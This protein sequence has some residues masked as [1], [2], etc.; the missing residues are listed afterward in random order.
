MIS[1][2]ELKKRICTVQSTQ[3]ITKVMSL[4]SAS[5]IKRLKYVLDNTACYKQIMSD[6]LYITAMNSSEKYDANTD[7]SVVIPNEAFYIAINT[8]LD[9]QYK[10]RHHNVKL[11]HATLARSPYP[12]KARQLII[13]LTSDKGL[14]GS[15]NSSIIRNMLNIARDYSGTTDF[16]CVGKKSYEALSKMHQYKNHIVKKYVTLHYKYLQSKI[17]MHKLTTSI[18]ELIAE[19]AYTSVKV[20]YTQFVT[21]LKQDV[22]VKQ[23]LPLIVQDDSGARNYH[24]YAFDDK[25]YNSLVSLLPYYIHSIVHN[26]V[27]H[28]FLSEAVKRM[29]TMDNATSNSQEMLNKY[30]L[31]YNRMRQTKVTMELIEVI[32]GMQG[33]SIK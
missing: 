20:V 19:H 31:Q 12:Q 1:L 15:F 16:L 3:K 26:C 29:I 4:I 2:K 11:P 13:V 18:F 23:I 5:Q 22:V 9:I 8:F 10:V 24:Q 27:L 14:C 7:S 28:S 30:T 17:V 32:S 6:I 21:T 33:L 25:P